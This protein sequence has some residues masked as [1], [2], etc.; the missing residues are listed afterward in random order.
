MAQCPLSSNWWMTTYRSMLSIT[1][2]DDPFTTYMFTHSSRINLWIL[3]PDLNTKY[4]IYQWA[5][6]QIRKIAGCACAGNAGNVFPRHRIQRKPR[7]NDPGMHHGTCVP[8]IPG[9]CAP[10]ILRIW[11]EA[12]AAAIVI[13]ILLLVFVPSIHSGRAWM[14]KIFILPLTGREC[15]MGIE[16]LSRVLGA[17]L[18]WHSINVNRCLFSSHHLLVSCVWQKRVSGWHLLI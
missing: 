14:H 8:N 12:H 2:Q 16:L 3:S 6:D 9:A 7:V 1:S 17:N 11:Q 15:L 18:M 5:S 10:A 4:N 13:S